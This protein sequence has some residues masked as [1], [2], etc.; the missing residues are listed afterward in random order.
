MRRLT[1]LVFTLIAVPIGIQAAM[2]AHAG[3]PTSWARADW[4]SS[5]QAPA[6]ARVRG[7]TVQIWAARSGR[8]K[9]IFADHT[10][11]A[12]KPAGARRYERYDVVGWG[13]PVRRNGWPVDAKWYSNQPR[14]VHEVRGKEAARLI[15]KI[16]AAIRRYPARKRG[17]YRVWPGPNSNSFVA[18]VTREVPEI[19]AEMPAT[20]IGKDWLGGGFSLARTPSGSGWQVSLGG[21]IGGALAW[22]EGIE[23]HLLGATIG[24]DPNDLA[25]KLPGLG[26]VS[27][28]P[29]RPIGT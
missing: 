2:M 25:I 6:A 23:L 3:W 7:A 11:I 18:W 4:S 8:W 22:E 10:W 13:R 15:P 29:S 14:V 21:V 24:I 17:D 5:G 19:G 26:S 12:L 27:A 16:R 20:A 1:L 28:L 9:G